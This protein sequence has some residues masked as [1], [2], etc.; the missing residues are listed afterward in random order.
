MAGIFVT[1]ADD[2]GGALITQAPQTLA[3]PQ[4]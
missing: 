1:M 4:A 2:H 3:H